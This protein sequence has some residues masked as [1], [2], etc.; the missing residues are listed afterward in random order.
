M[1]TDRDSYSSDDSGN[2]SDISD[3]SGLDNEDLTLACDADGKAL[4]PCGCNRRRA[5][6]TIYQHLRNARLRRK[7][8]KK[9]PRPLDFDEPDNIDG[10][11]ALQGQA[12][13]IHEAEDDEQPGESI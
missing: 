10:L 7:L 1:H 4:C 13:Q 11:E 12:S 9:R 2:S 8:A 5:L 3:N 6:R